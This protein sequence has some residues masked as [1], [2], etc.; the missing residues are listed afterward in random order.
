MGWHGEFD[1]YSGWGMAADHRTRRLT[2]TG[3]A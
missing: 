3:R 2:L 1:L